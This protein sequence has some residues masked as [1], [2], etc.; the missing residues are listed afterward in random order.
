MSKRWTKQKAGQQQSK[1]RRPPP[2]PG[3]TTAARTTMGSMRSGLRRFLG[4]GSGKPKGAAE[5]LLD[6][7][8]WI[9]VI[10][11]GFYFLQNRCMG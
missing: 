6:G 11:A 10:V 7:I 5:K 1:R 2:G 4:G 8:L 3:P 9:A